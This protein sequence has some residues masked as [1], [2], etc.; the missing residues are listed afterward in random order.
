MTAVGRLDRL[1]PITGW[2][3]RYNRAWLRGDIAA[4]IAVTALVVPKNLGY[5][6]IAGVPVENGLYAAAAGAL[7]YAL[8]CTSRQISTGPVLLAR[9]G[10]GR[11]SACDGPRRQGRCA[12]RRRDHARRR[13]AVPAS[14]RVQDGLDRAVPLEGGRHRLPRRRRHRRDD[15]RAAEAH[16]YLVERGQRL[17][18]ALDLVPGARRHP[19]GDAR[20]R[21][22]LARDDSCAPVR[23]PCCPGRARAR[24]RRARRLRGLRS[25]RPRRR[26]G[27]PRSPRSSFARAAALAARP[28]APGDDRARLVRPAPDRVLADRR[29][30]PGVRDAPPL[31]DRRQP[32][33]RRPGHGERHG[34]ACSRACRSRRA[35]RRAP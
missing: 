28:H 31:P 3:P 13:G 17:A 15:R 4:G 21:A 22:R 8:F 7:V 29:R 14:R 30:R 10:R 12:A 33:V 26:A 27:R 19:L 34:G 18:R 35:S 2:L 1:L 24:R 5:A 16:R 32:G 11:R 23:R 25:R 20:R 6:G 9:R